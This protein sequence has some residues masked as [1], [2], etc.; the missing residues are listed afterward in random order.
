MGSGWA[1]TTGIKDLG[2]IDARALTETAAAEGGAQPERTRARARP[3]QRD[4]EPRANARF[5][6]LMTG[7]FN[8]GGGGG[9]FGGGG[10][11]NR[12]LGDA[13]PGDKVFSDLFTLRSDIGNPI[14]RQTPIQNNDR[15][16][17]PVTW[18]E[19]G[20]LR[21]W[22]GDDT[23]ASLNMSLVMEGSDQSVED[24]IAQTRAACSSRSSG[25]SAACRPIRSRC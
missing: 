5:L 9:G 20:I 17:A 7:V 14:L 19:N 13:E 11:G 23:P 4:L 12:A 2:M 15:P 22:A 6:S 1:G 10:G 24:M 3:L 8:R 18:V 21:N 25:T 16:A